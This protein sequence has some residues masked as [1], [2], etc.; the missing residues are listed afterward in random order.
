MLVT[1]R[2]TPPGLLVSL[3]IEGAVR[4]VAARRRPIGVQVVAAVQRPGL[5]PYLV[6]Y[7]LARK[8]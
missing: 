6:S 2:Q 1:W 5:G 4:A 8:P 3:P 7:D